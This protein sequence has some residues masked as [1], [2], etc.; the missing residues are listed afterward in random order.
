[1]DSGK[2]LK[3]KLFKIEESTNE[4]YHLVSKGYIKEVDNELNY[5][6][7]DIVEVINGIRYLLRDKFI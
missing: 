6:L 2:L 7:D 3:D 5:N 1:M 4:A